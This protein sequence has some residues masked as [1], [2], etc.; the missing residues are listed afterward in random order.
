MKIHLR[1]IGNSKGIIIPKSVILECSIKEDV[2][3]KVEN[4]SITIIADELKPRQNWKEIFLASGVVESNE[5]LN[6]VVVAPMT[7]TVR[8]YPTRVFSNINNRK[9]EII[10]DQIR[11]VGTKRLIK[12]LD[13][14]SSSKVKKEICGIL[15]EMFTY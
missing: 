12:K 1:K 5:V 9:G 14:I 15:T 7:S 10:L 11:T 6:T 4:G 8:N 13:R 2:L 3:L